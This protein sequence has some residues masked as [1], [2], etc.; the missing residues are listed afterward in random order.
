MLMK[1]CMQVE[2]THMYEFLNNLSSRST[3]KL[4]DLSIYVCVFNEEKKI[5]T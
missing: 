4:Y 1:F 2:D 3:S 5:I